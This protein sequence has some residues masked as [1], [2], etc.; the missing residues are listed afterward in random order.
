MTWQPGGFFIY[1]LATRDHIY[2]ELSRRDTGPQ[3]LVSR[4]PSCEEGQTPEKITSLP[5]MPRSGL[6]WNKLES[7][8]DKQRVVIR[9]NGCIISAACVCVCARW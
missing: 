9:F 8:S 6:P 5:I 7:H 4:R 3:L 1:Y 2:S